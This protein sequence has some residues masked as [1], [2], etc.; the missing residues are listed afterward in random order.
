MAAFTTTAQVLGINGFYQ[1]TAGG[2][3]SV[4]TATSVVTLTC[5]DLSKLVLYGFNPSG[6]DDITCTISASTA[7]D[8]AV[9]CKG[10]KIITTA[11]ATSAYFMIAGLESNWFQSTSN[12]VVFTFS[13]AI[14]VMAIELTSTRYI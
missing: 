8:R 1:S 12:T 11:I 3:I 7:P 9:A 4:S 6:V 10:N 5:G 13:T 14:A 2:Q